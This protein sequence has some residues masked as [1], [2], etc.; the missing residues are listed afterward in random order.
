MLLVDFQGMPRSVMVWID[1]RWMSV[2]IAAF[3]LGWLRRQ[4]F[5]QLLLRGASILRWPGL[6]RFGGS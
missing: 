2:P 3:S 6:D 1:S 4:E 5:C